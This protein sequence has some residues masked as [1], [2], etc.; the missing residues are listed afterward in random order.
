MTHEI[1]DPSVLPVAVLHPPHPM[2]LLSQC[3]IIFS[4]HSPSSKFN[5]PHISPH[6]MLTS[7][8]LPHQML[9]ASPT[10]PHLVYFTLLQPILLTL[11][12]KVHREHTIFI[13]NG[14]FQQVAQ[15]RQA[16]S[17][18]TNRGFNRL[19]W[20]AGLLPTCTENM[21]LHVSPLFCI[22]SMLSTLH[23]LACLNL[24]PSH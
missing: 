7:Y 21:E 2:L 8:T 23:S 19:F 15:Q 13:E 16:S 17:N 5:A 11:T 22:A 18:I 6:P 14:I 10:L 20:T 24:A 4:L 12:H 3:S 9:L 1:S